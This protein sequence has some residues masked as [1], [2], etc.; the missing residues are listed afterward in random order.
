MSSRPRRANRSS[1][2]DDDS[3][4]VVT[5]DD[6]IGRVKGSDPGTDTVEA[7]R[8]LSLR[9]ETFRKWLME[10]AKAT[11][12]PAICIVNGEATDGTRNAPVLVFEAAPAG[13]TPKVTAAGRVGVIDGES[14]QALY[15]R[16]MGCQIR[17]VRE[18][19]K[20]E[21]IMAIPRGAMVTPDL[22][23]SS[24]AG[25]AILACCKEPTGGKNFWDAFENTTVCENK[26]SIRA[27]RQNGPQ[28]LVKILQER[29]KVEQAYKKHA[30][31]S[32]D[33]GGYTLAKPGTISTRAPLL[34]FL[35]HQRFSNSE[36]P[37][38]SAH[39]FA[40]VMEADDGNALKSAERVD[41]S[42]D[43]PDTFAPYARTLPSS[44][45][46]PLCWKRNE[47][48][49]LTGCLSGLPLLQ[50]VSNSTLHL[51]SE[52]LTLLKAGV[53]KRFPEVFP[54][55][56][57]TW[58]RWVWAAAISASRTLPA[59][60]YIDA[61]VKDISAFRPANP[62][63]FQSPADYWKE[64]GVMI[65]LL[66]ML[67]H[68]IEANQ[69]T[70]K[71]PV[72]GDGVPDQRSSSDDA[73]DEPSGPRPPRAIAHKKVRKGSELFTCY[74]NLANH[75]LVAQYGFALVNNSCDEVRM[76]WGLADGV[77][78]ARPP[79]DHTPDFHVSD[80]FV[81]E[82]ND[83]EVITSWWSE[84]RLNLLKREA[85]CAVDDSVVPLLVSGKKLITTAYND[86]SYDPILLTVAVVATMPVKNLDKNLSTETE[87]KVVLSARHQSILQHYLEFCFSRKLEK[88]L[89]NLDNGLKSHFAGIN[90][91]TKSAEGGLEYDAEAAELKEGGASGVKY[92]SWQT[93]F[94]SHAYSSAMEVEKHYY[95]LGTDSCVLTLYD[96]Q[97]RALQTSLSGISSDGK[98]SS[99]VQKLLTD[100]G[101]EL[102]GEDD[103]GDEEV[104]VVGDQKVAVAGDEEVAV[105]GDEEVTESQPKETAASEATSN[106][107]EVGSPTRETA[108]SSHEASSNGLEASGKNGRDE[109]GSRSP[110]NRKRNRKNRNSSGSKPPA[111]KL[112]VG[113][114]SYKTTPSDLYDYFCSLYGDENVLECH[115]PTERD[116]GQSRGFGFVAMPEEIALRVLHSGKKHE[117]G[118]RAVKIAKSN[119]VG[120]GTGGK[121]SEGPTPVPSDRCST[122]GYRPKYCTCKPNAPG[123]GRGMGRPGPSSERLGDQG[124]PP[125]GYDYHGAP[126]DRHRDDRFRDYYDDHDRYGDN[127]RDRRSN[128]PR[129]S[130]RS[131]ERSEERRM[132]RDRDRSRERSPDSRS[133]RWEDSRGPRPER[134]SDSSWDRDRKRS[135]SRSRE[136]D[137]N[138]KKKSKRR[139]SS[140]ATP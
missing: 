109:N 134:R 133:R 117:V 71:P 140:L 94:D 93:F 3:E 116:T 110:R 84:D 19:K 2:E 12:H 59:A 72:P 39:D 131:Y 33:P 9:L 83:E 47:L 64:L 30:E 115:I 1:Q 96:G 66:D 69:V 128:W 17:T 119:S 113:N 50:D 10:E 89:Q 36:R 101:F 16:T 52:F 44:V 73:N 65:P 27:P 129:D 43:S 122:C 60:C 28:I 98:L 8:A 82:S 107:R 70:W 95:S 67:N 74:G 100:L 90:L 23:A 18:I 6:I 14:H 136:R 32:G 46:I 41:P 7:A 81:F 85:L 138:R 4:E 76:G 114:L 53:L 118:G 35:I 137:I 130:S 92:T 99:T 135:R 106:G 126:P 20:D 55:G 78:E 38:L 57:L 111:L 37:P 102:G 54:E 29:K 103:A 108:S 63:E 22:V 105:A 21:T 15:D 104:A 91:W 58:E 88:L 124:P 86:G 45:S 24:D 25:K 48:A 61:G 139:S 79:H 87:S 5:Y 77:G 34:A 40:R 11:I 121:G 123:F 112:H 42:P 49:L 75:D 120:S 125:R 62:L 56:L 127:D 26:L 97:L 80:D 132:R 31:A 68:E 51:V 13:S